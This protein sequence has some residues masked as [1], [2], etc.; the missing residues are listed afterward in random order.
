MPTK[1]CNG[2]CPQCCA[3]HEALLAACKRFVKNAECTCEGGGP[4]FVCDACEGRA[5][6]E[7]AEAIKGNNRR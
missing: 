1:Q 5:A 6:I 2:E 3:C 4:G 7:K